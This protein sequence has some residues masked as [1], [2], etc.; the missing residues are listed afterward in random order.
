MENAYVMKDIKEKIAQFMYVIAMEEVNVFTTRSASVMTDSMEIIVKR[1][2]VLKTAIIMEYVSKESACARQVGEENLVIWSSVK[3]TVLGEEYARMVNVNVILDL[4]E[5]IVL[6]LTVLTIV[7]EM[8]NV[9][10][11]N[12]FV[13][14]TSSTLIVVLNIVQM[15]VLEM[16]NAKM[17]IV[18]VSQ[19]FQEMDVNF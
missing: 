5:K 16:G 18:N 15:I 12:A 11:I 17:D 10:G 8:E 7:Q 19:G 6:Y 13:M 14:P 9:S 2:S 3:K 4:Q 1:S